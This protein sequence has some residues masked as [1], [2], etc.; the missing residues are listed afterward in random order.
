VNGREPENE[1]ESESGHNPGLHTARFPLVARA[2]FGPVAQAR[3]QLGGLLVVSL[4]FTAGCEKQ[5]PAPVAATDT[6]TNIV[7]SLGGDASSPLPD[8][9]EHETLMEELGRAD[10]LLSA[11]RPTE[12]EKAYRALLV[13]NPDLEEVHFNLGFLLSRAGRTNEAIH[14][15]EEALRVLPDYAEAH[16]N[17]G[18]LLVRLKRFDEALPHFEASLKANPGNSSTHNNLGTV[19]GNLGQLTNAI[20]HFTR[21]AQLNPDYAEAW[22]NLGRTYGQLGRWE[23]AI[24]PLRTAVELRPD[25]KSARTLLEAARA[26][27]PRPN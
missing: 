11:G 6:S 1:Q 7:F 12:A 25:L 8:D 3:V 4:L 2:R 23:E 17:L 10:A 13:K 5:P 18:N 14:H 21:A 9:R 19:L 16:N 22:F 15:Y 24:P 20:T 27:M 26:R